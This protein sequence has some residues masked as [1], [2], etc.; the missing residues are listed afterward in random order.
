MKYQR[1]FWKNGRFLFFFFATKI[2]FCLYAL[3]VSLWI[4]REEEDSFITWKIFDFLKWISLLFMVRTGGVIACIVLC[5]TLIQHVQRSILRLHA[6]TMN[7]TICLINF[8]SFN[9]I[10][11]IYFSLSYF[12]R[13]AMQCNA[14]AMSV[15]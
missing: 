3:S 1:K 8:S 7:F 14:I 12:T 11:K 15:L 6:E 5:S 13:Y 4:E 10:L 9:L 2:T